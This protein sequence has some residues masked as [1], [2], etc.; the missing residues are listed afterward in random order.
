MKI[1]GEIDF[2]EVIPVLESYIRDKFG[3]R[4]QIRIE[5]VSYKGYTFEISDL[6]EPLEPEILEV[7]DEAE[8]PKVGP[9]DGNEA[10]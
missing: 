8:E 2:R 4:G 9:S 10:D 6:F 1:R 3:M 7:V 5:H